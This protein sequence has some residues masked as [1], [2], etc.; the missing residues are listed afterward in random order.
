MI[1]INKIEPSGVEGGCCVFQ[2]AFGCCALGKPVEVSFFVSDCVFTR[3]EVKIKKNTTH[4]ADQFP[5][6]LNI[7]LP[8]FPNFCIKIWEKM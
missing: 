8:I 5:V 1:A 6:V 2:P 7:V 4:H 3:F